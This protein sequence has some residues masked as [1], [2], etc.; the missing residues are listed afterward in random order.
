MTEKNNKNTL[1]KYKGKLYDFLKKNKYTDESVE[2]FTHLSYGPF[3]GKFVITKEN[4]KEFM[5]LYIAAINNGVNDLVILEKQKEFAPIII[6]IDLKIPHENY[7]NKRLYNDKLILNI[8][9]KYIDTIQLYLNVKKDNLNFVLLEKKHADKKDL[10]YK[11]GFHIMFPLI[12]VN[13]KIRHLIRHKVVQL[14]NE[15]NTFER[16]SN[17]S[18]DIIDKAVVS[19]NGWFLYGSSKPGSQIYKISKIFTKKLKVIY[20]HNKKEIYDNNTGEIIEEGCYDDEQ[21]INY[22]SIHGT[23]FSKKYATKLQNEYVESDI[24]AECE[25]LGISSNIRNE[26]STSLPCVSKELEID[27]ATKFVAMLDHNRSNNFIDW[28][29]VGLVLHGIDQTLLYT[30][31]DFSKH[32]K[33]FKDGECEKR[34]KTIRT[35]SNGNMLT[36]SSLAFWAKMDNPKLYNAYIKEEFKSMMNKSLNGETYYLAKSFYAKYS[37]K[38]VC[39]SIDK[40]CWWEFKDHKW[41][42]IEGGYSL[43]ILFSEDFVNE[44]NREIGEITTAA[45]Q[46]QGFYKEELQ[47]KRLKIDSIVDKLMNCSFKKLLL[48]EC[49]NIFYDSKFEQKL[50]S[51]IYLLGFEN[52]VYDLEQ[53]I[54]RDGRPDDYITLSTNHN[55]SKWNENDPYNK[56]LFKFFEQVLPNDIIRKYFLNVLCTCLSG[57]TKEEKLYI[58]TGSGSNGKTLTIDLMINALGDYYMTCPITIITRKRG[59][60]NETSPE[61][62]RM[63]GKR[64]GVFQEADKGEKLNVGIMKEFTGGDKILVRDLFKGSNEMIEFKPQMKYFLTCNE[65]PDVPSGDDGTWRRLRVINF[66]SKFT[67]NPIKPNEFKIDNTLKDKIEPWGGT[68]ISYLIHI[69]NTEYKLLDY[70]VD[71]DEVMASTNQYKMENDFYTEYINNRIT[72]TDS[73]KNI[74]KCDS[75]YE[76]FKNWYKNNYTNGTIPKKLDITKSINRII[77]D[78]NNKGGYYEKVI[79]KQNEIIASEFDVEN[80]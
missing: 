44:Y 60:S 29:R 79:F 34:W 48:T 21:I 2:K 18:D 13:S 73:K 20:D 57:Q 75:I 77:G 68:F 35:N 47:R 80:D 55:Y 56:Q 40:N 16:Y 33:K 23:L 19:S 61:K 32:S 64:C 39:S 17:N 59:Q 25:Q 12:S 15:D 72:I 66:S 49:K 50:D 69:Y 52:G 27:K 51:N 6:D 5:D 4:R 3:Q 41:Y 71:P 46:Q 30:W 42:R 38:F 53:S 14:C 74:I 67:D 7:E 58:M 54:F 31:I 65:L 1:S 63:K 22:L 76:D 78:P 10:I 26:L 62:V 37:D 11:D 24:D 45:I 36:I 9:K 28:M 8:A 70:L 43:L